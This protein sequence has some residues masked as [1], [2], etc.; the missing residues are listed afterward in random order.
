MGMTSMQAYPGEVQLDLIAANPYS[1]VGQLH[2][3]LPQILAAPGA[4]SV[5][6]L[7]PNTGNLTGVN[8][9][10]KYVRGYFQSYNFTVQRELPGDLLAS[11]GYV[12]MHAAHLQASVNQNYGQLGG[13]TA[14][15]PLAWIPD[16]SAGIT[17]LLPWGAD[18]YNSLQATLNKRFSKGLQFQAAYTFSKDIGMATSILI[19][20]YINRDY[21]TTGADRTH[22]IVVSASY[23][24][25]F[26]KGKPMAT[27]GVGAAA[28][29]GCIPGRHSLSPQADLPAIARVIRRPRT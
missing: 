25:P 27:H 1:Y 28:L 13:G 14:S 5:Y 2:T 17:A 23:E 19:P 21:Y 24:L 11:I 16:Y 29:S 7:L 26:G 18:K 4:N 10:K 20:Q 15:Q 3:G 6:P 9:N 22:H 8:T 12:G